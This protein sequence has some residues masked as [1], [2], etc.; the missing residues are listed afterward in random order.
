MT[1]SG[2]SD[3]F[4]CTFLCCTPL[5]AQAVLPGLGALVLQRLRNICIHPCGKDYPYITEYN[6]LK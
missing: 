1:L 6:L 3:I 2:F 4:E 5:S